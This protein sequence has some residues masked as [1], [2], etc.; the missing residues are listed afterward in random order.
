MKKILSFIIA[1]VM[2]LTVGVTAFAAEAMEI[3]VG[4]TLALAFTVDTTNGVKVVDVNNTLTVGEPI[5]TENGVYVNV[6]AKAGDVGKVTKIEVRTKDGK[7]VLAS[8]LI[9]IVASPVAE[10]VAPVVLDKA[11]VEV[12]TVVDETVTVMMNGATGIS[13]E[14]YNW[15][16]GQNFEKIVFV[17]EN[18]KWTLTRGDYTKM[19]ITAPIYFDVKVDTNLWTEDKDGNVVEDFTL[20]NKVLK[21]LGNTKLDVFYVTVTDDCNIGNIASKPELEVVIDTDWFLYANSLNVDAFKFNG[22]S[23]SLVAKNVAVKYVSGKLP[24]NITTGGTYVFVDSAANVVTPSTKPTTKPN[25]PTG[26]TN[27]AAAVVAIAV[28]GA[29]VAGTKFIVK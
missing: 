25:A 21:A 6:T 29:V 2:L 19:N 10:P 22:E 16:K 5:V 24:L 8:E 27:S 18:Y 23:V 4:K 3:E 15:L 12:S 13:A 14:A 1:A 9:E 28:M 7:T 20:E 17:G 11:A 26:G